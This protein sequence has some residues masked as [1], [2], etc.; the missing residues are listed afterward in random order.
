MITE[1]ILYAQDKIVNG[2]FALSNDYGW[3]ISGTWTR[4]NGSIEKTPSLVGSISQSNI[5]K[6]GV[7]Y[8]IQFTITGRTAG[9]LDLKCGSALTPLASYTTNNKFIVTFTADGTDIYFSSDASWDGTI[10]NVSVTPL[11]GQT[12]LDLTDEV[13]IP[14]NFA[15]D[16]IFDL[17]KRKG[18][19]SKTIRLPGTHKNNLAFGH[20]Y[21][22]NSDSIF[23]V[24]KPSRVVIKNSGLIVFEGTMYVSKV[25]EKIL[26][27]NARISYNVFI[28]GEAINIFDKLGDKSIRDLDFSQWDHPFDINTILFSSAANVDIGSPFVISSNMAYV[29]D[30]TLSDYVPNQTIDYTSPSILAI[31]SET[32]NGNACVGIQFS[33]NHSGFTIGDTINIVTDNPYLIGTQV[34][35][36]IPAA[37]KIT[38]HMAYANCVS[39]SFNVAS[40]VEKR[41]WHAEGYYYPMCDNGHFRTELKAGTGLV[42]GLL[43]TIKVLDPRDDFST[44]TKDIHTFAP[45]TP[46]EGMTFVATIGGASGD[47]IDTTSIWVFNSILETYTEKDAGGTLTNK[48]LTANHWFLQDFVPCIFARE[49]WIKMFQ[50]IGYDYDLPF[51]DSGLFRRLIIPMDSKFNVNELG[52]ASP[53][54]VIMNTWLPDMKLKEFFISILNMF[55]YIIKEDKDNHNL[56]SFPSRNN[57]FNSNV[58]RWPLD[59]SKELSVTLASTLLP[60]YYF[61]KYKDCDDFFN[62]DY[63]AEFGN[64]TNTSGILNEGDRTYGDRFISTGNT[65]SKEVTKVELYFSPTVMAGNLPGIY[66]TFNLGYGQDK[67]FSVTYTADSTGESVSR[68]KENRILIAGMRGTK[69]PW[70]FT[71]TLPVTGADFLRIDI[72]YNLGGRMHPYAMHIDNILDA[73][74]WIDL[75][76]DPILGRYFPL[77]P[78]GEPDFNKWLANCLS[79]Q[80]WDRHLRIILDPNTKLIEGDFVIKSLDINKLDFQ[81]RYGLMEYLMRLNRITDWDANGTGIAK[82]EFLKL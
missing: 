78:S 41:T 22:I 79:G 25:N 28:R 10:Q 47:S 21:Q 12:S 57:F 59:A 35:G 53:D 75:N 11:P 71:G 81:D 23:D 64:I 14:L 18:S 20:C 74:P 36:D 65:S 80:N 48:N 42:T 27:G 62:Q 60:R 1:F 58:T 44:V 72:A 6:A 49:V 40:L 43:Y 50:L 46:V 5:L 38:L 51:I 61:L 82:A 8:K 13:I 52:T 19:F 56:I 39:T 67:V 17:G 55:N 31:T 29:W 73:V 15:I 16:N 2:R 3:T 70:S 68:G 9:T 4:A 77:Q 54:H 34:I 26:N 76:F 33:S 69:F 66:D 63:E 30:N 7:D 32:F 24:R 45:M 37:D